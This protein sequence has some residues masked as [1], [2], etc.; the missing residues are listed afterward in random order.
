M[1]RINPKI[2]TVEEKKLIGKSK[3]MSLDEDYS[4]ELWKS[5][6]PPRHSIPNRVDDLYYNIKIFDQP[7]DPDHFD[8]STTFVKWAAVEVAQHEFEEVADM[9]T[10]LFSGGLYAMFLH[11]GPAS[12]F[13]QTLQ[14]IFEEWLP[15]SSYDLDDREHFERLTEDYHPAD[16]EAVEEVWIPIRFRS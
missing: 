9:E 6:M 11:R 4:Q 5:F 10:Y 15:S 14:Y 3:R 12:G 16:S 7:F 1:R 2:I 13:N 8:T